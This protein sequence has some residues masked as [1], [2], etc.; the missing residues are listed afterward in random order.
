MTLDRTLRPAFQLPKSAPSINLESLDSQGRH[1]QNGTIDAAVS[2]IELSFPKTFNPLTKGSLFLLSKILL[3]GTNK[4]DKETFHNQLDG[5]GAFL[6]ITS[7]KDYIS[8]TLHGLNRKLDQALDLVTELLEEPNFNPE[9]F[10]NVLTQARQHFAISLEKSS[11]VAQINFEKHLFG[12]DSV[13]AP[14]ER[15]EELDHVKI[16]DLQQAWTE[17]IQ[18]KTPFVF[19]T[20]NVSGQEICSRFP[21]DSTI[22]SKNSVLTSTQFSDTI[23]KEDALQSA[24][25][26]GS[27]SINQ[28][29]TD[30]YALSFANT[31]FGGYFGS[32]LMQNIREDKGYTYGIY[33]SIRH[34]NNASYWMI[35]ADVKK[36]HREDAITEIKKE[37]VKL[38]AEPVAF[39]EISTVANYLKGD[40]LS[41]LASPFDITS[42]WK[43]MVLRGL[44]KSFYTDYYLSLDNNSPESVKRMADQ[45]MN[46]E[47]I[48]QIIVG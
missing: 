13:Y 3:E 43:T 33:S 8:I 2:K 46:P 26:L 7:S 32:R 24:I 23:N 25:R 29:S 9:I 30:Y 44:P 5:C 27:S 15:I 10:S 19:V 28:Q 11:T 47:K 18:G 36:M 37:L 1:W 20:S 42:R 6:D 17:C 16:E 34:L 48:S 41:S 39:D 31:L 40:L 45:Y 21:N 38:V 4:K 35:G 14:I 22:E 12:S